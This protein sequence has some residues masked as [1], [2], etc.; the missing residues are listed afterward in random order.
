[1]AVPSSLFLQDCD[2]DDFY[3]FNTDKTAIVD[4]G[5]TKCSPSD[6]QTESG[7]WAFNSN[8]TKL[9]LMLPNS[10]LNGDADIKELSATTLHLYSSQSVSG[11]AYTVDATFV[12]N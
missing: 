1:M 3:K 10:A 5:P 12:P 2:K 6:P 4:A 8:E 9:T 7:T 11:T